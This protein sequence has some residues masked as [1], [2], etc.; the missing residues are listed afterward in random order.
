MGMVAEI[1]LTNCLNHW[2]PIL[3]FGLNVEVLV[4]FGDVR[5]VVAVAFAA[6]PYVLQHLHL[7]FRS[8]FSS[9]YEGPVSG[10]RYSMGRAQLPRLPRSV[11]ISD[12]PTR[13]TD[14]RNCRRHCIVETPG[15]IADDPAAN[16]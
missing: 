4:P 16:L 9:V 11:A 5:V 14:H 7:L 6:A 8:A 15:C 3:L 12:I 10:W 2:P 13:P 1:A